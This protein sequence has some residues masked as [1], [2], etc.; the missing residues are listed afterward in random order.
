[1]TN[2]EA[3]D[4]VCNLNLKGYAKEGINVQRHR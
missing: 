1:M 4:F 2:E 3:Y